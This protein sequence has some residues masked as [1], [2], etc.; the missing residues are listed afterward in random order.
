MAQEVIRLEEIEDPQDASKVAR[1]VWP[2]PLDFS[3]GTFYQ[4]R[5]GREQTRHR[6]RTKLSEPRKN[7]CDQ[8]GSPVRNRGISRRP[9]RAAAGRWLPREVN[10]TQGVEG[11]VL[12]GLLPPA[13]NHRRSMW[14][15]SAPREDDGDF[16]RQQSGVSGSPIMAR[17]SVCV[18]RARKSAPSWG[19][20]ASLNGWKTWARKRSA[21]LRKGVSE[22]L[23]GT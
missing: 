13:R 17:F 3:L 1:T 18:G 2:D 8:M 15:N 5:R 21:P 12:L 6:E 4:L 16:E 14:R 11:G 10:E 22:Y 19:N 23:G 20:S 7:N 9:H